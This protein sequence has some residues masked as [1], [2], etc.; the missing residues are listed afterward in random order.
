M[1]GLDDIGLTLKSL[2]S[3]DK[4]EKSRQS[5]KPNTKTLNH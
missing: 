1:E 5:I 2:D 4:F 3:I